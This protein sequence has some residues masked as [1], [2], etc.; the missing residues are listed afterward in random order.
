L[1]DEG[2][3]LVGP[4]GEEEPQGCV[5]GKDAVVAVAVDVGWREDVGE[6][7][8]LLKRGFRSRA[9]CGV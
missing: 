6:A 2:V 9:W 5:G 4:L 3:V 1:S 7:A 8:Q